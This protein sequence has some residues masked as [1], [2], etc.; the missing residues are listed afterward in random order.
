MAV[1]GLQLELRN[2]SNRAKKKNRPVKKQRIPLKNGKGNGS[3]AQSAN[4]LVNFE[5][6]PLTQNNT[7][8]LYFMVI[9]EDAADDTVQPSRGKREEKHSESSVR[10]IRRLEQELASTKEH[11]QSVIESQEA[12]NEELQSANEQLP[13]IN[14]ELRNRNIE[15]N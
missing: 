1:D 14:D 3:S 12:T 10:Q 11:L 6:T 4:R 7:K 9:F 15:V 5:V 2:A 8:E 13:T